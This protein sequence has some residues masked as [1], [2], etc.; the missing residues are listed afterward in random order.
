MAGLS[1]QL[2]SLVGVVVGVGGSLLVT[3][4]GDRSRFRR[5]QVSRWRERRL[6]GYA[7]YA[8]AMKANVNVMY[9]LADH[10]GG[11]P[12]PHRL[13]PEQAEPLLAATVEARDQA[14]ET[15]SLIGSADVAAAANVWFGV[16]AEMERTLRDGV[17]DTAVWDELATRHGDVRRRFYDA[18]KADLAIGDASR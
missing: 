10:L 7:D 14:W 17:G 3:T 6:A 13:T 18:A 4:V 16:V 15:L 5:D 11:A 12:S 9:R 2:P 8:R 1:E